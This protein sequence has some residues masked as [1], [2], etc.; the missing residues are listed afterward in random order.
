MADY[1][2]EREFFVYKDQLLDRLRTS[3]AV[4]Q[5]VEKRQQRLMGDI[6]L[7]LQVGY[8]YYEI[9]HASKWDAYSLEDLSLNHLPRKMM[10]GPSAFKELGHNLLIFVKWLH[11][12]QIVDNGET[13]V[14]TMRKVAPQ[15]ASASK[16]Y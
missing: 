5:L 9:D 7:V 1:L 15:M 13:L 3:T 11:A 2:S 8:N 6:D 4:T 16:K 12:E 10:A 14:A